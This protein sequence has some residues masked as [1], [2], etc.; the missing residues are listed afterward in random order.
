MGKLGFAASS[1]EIVMRMVKSY[2]FSVLFN[3]EKLEQFEPTRGIRQGD[4][5]SLTFS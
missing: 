1:V 3:G 2:S 5:T 4:P